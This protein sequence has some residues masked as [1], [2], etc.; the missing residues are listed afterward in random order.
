MVINI[1]TR[2]RKVAKGGDN[3]TASCTE[4]LQNGWKLLNNLA[5]EARAKNAHS[6]GCFINIFPIAKN[7]S[8]NAY[9]SYVWICE[10]FITF[11]HMTLCIC[12]QM[13]KKSNQEAHSK[14]FESLL[15]MD[16]Q[17]KIGKIRKLKY[18][19]TILA[20]KSF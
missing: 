14:S 16:S 1:N 18:K 8:A 10:L 6:T 7:I 5:I 3:F 20:L 15:S 11:A 13:K 19:K 4:I 2:G 12:F 17:E 9:N